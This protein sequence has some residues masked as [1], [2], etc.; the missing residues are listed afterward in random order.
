[1]KNINIHMCMHVS[2]PHSP[3][4]SSTIQNHQKNISQEE[5]HCTDAAREVYPKQETGYIGQ[6]TLQM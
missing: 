4:L 3:L 1:M 5:A 2:K 6:T